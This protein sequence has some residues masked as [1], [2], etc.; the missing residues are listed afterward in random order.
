MFFLV[1]P[2]FHRGKTIPPVYCSKL[3]WNVKRYY[4]LLAGKDLHRVIAITLPPYHP[5]A[6]AAIPIN[7]RTHHRIMPARCYYGEDIRLPRS[8]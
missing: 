2:I 4:P 6:I 8:H 3:P 1:K 5:G 7:R